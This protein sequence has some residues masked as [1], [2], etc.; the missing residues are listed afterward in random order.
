MGGKDDSCSVLKLSRQTVLPLST[1]HNVFGQPEDGW[2]R[3]PNT[4]QRSSPLRCDTDQSTQ[5]PLDTSPGG[6]M[7][8]AEM[9]ESSQMNAHRQFLLLLC[10]CLDYLWLFQ[11]V[12]SFSLDSCPAASCSGVKPTYC[13]KGRF[14]ERRKHFTFLLGKVSLKGLRRILLGFLIT[15]QGLG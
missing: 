6:L 14:H 11:A 13:F 10:C 2:M 15:L 1:A 8:E 5:L 7:L 12:F 3:Y 4:E 9:S